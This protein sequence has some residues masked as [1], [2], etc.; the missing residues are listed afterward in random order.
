MVL[1]KVEGN[2]EVEEDRETQI[3]V[4]LAVPDMAKV[5]DVE[6][7]KAGKWKF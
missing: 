4:S 1:V 5:V 7:A 2:P 3:L 6:E